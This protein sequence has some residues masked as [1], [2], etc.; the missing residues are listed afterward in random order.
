MNRIFRWFVL[1]LTCSAM[2]AS[3]GWAVLDVQ[4][5]DG[6]PDIWALFFEAGAL[7]PDEDTDGDGMSNAVEAAAGTNPF[8]PGSLVK[9]TALTR[10]DTGI[11][12]TFPTLNGKRYQVQSS[13]TVAGAVWTNRGTVLSGSVSDRV[14]PVR[15]TTTGPGSGRGRVVR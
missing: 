1:S 14:R 13:P 12:L 5:A 4:P 11:H 10:D 15:E 7:V 9:I 3:R 8:Q 6:I 2:L